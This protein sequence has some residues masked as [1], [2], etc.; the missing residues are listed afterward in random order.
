MSKQSPSGVRPRARGALVI[1]ALSTAMFGAVT[2]A[3]TGAHAQVP[4]F[5]CKQ[6]PDGQSC[7]QGGGGGAGGWSPPDSYLWTGVVLGM[8]TYERS[9][10]EPVTDM[11][12]LTVQAATGNPHCQT[13]SY[14]RV[15]TVVSGV[16]C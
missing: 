13:L 2:A 12:V 10:G 3:S 11:D 7:T 4:P 14:H 8:N 5:H 15:G 1:L 6:S 16:A 9:D